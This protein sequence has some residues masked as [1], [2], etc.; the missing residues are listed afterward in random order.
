MSFLWP[1]LPHEASDWLLSEYGGLSIADLSQRA[2]T[3]HPDAAVAET[4]GAAVS[5]ENIEALRDGVIEIA[6]QHGFDMVSGRAGSSGTAFDRA[7]A[8]VM[9]EHMGTNAND[10]SSPEVWNFVTLVVLPD[11]A[12]WRWASPNGSPSDE[13]MLGRNVFR[14]AF[15]RLW[16]RAYILGTELIDGPNHLLEDEVVQ[17]TERPGLLRHPPFARAHARISRDAAIASG[18]VRTEAVRV[19]TRVAL[20]RLAFINPAVMSEEELNEFVHNYVGETDLGHLKVAKGSQQIEH[21]EDKEPDS[22]NSNTELPVENAASPGE[23]LIDKVVSIIDSFGPMVV[24]ACI[25]RCSDSQ[26]ASA[27][28]LT[29]SE[30]PKSALESA[31]E[32][33]LVELIEDNLSD[34]ESKTVFLAGSDRVVTRSLKNRRIEEV[35]LSE[36]QELLDQRGYTVNSKEQNW[37]QFLLDE[38]GEHEPSEA[39]GLHLSKISSYKYLR[40]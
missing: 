35:P 27:S 25:R 24:A 40:E 4:G 26:N 14:N 1:R 37:M 28:D 33:G 21:V 17:I 38:S 15:S 18:F 11:V 12:T 29:R 22:E 16:L 19:F 5:L 34:F 32:Q 30:T 31:L 23:S 8:R 9:I 7:A 39:V 3:F 20:R 6:R 2:S 10:L 13:R 36:L